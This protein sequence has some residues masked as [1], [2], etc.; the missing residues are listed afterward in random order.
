MNRD[1]HAYRIL[2]LEPQPCAR[3]LKYARGLR[4]ALG[5]RVA[6]VFG[7]LFYTL[8]E[9]YGQGNEVFDELVKLDPK[10]P[11]EDIK[12]LVNRVHPLLIHSHNAPDFLTTAAI[13]TVK[14][15]VPV[16]HD[17]H[18]ALTLRETGYYESDDEDTVR[19]EYP[20]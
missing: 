20:S 4:W 6:L 13:K 15:A 14:G 2:F 11:E 10:D 5:D 12:R 9:L 19:S 17:C 16:I 18:E 8:N 3:A 1:T 7:Y